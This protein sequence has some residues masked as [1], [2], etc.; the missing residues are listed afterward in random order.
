MAKKDELA[1]PQEHEILDSEFAVPFFDM[2]FPDNED[3]ELELLIDEARTNGTVS[4]V[5]NDSWV[6]E[7]PES[8]ADIDWLEWLEVSNSLLISLPHSIGCLSKLKVLK[9]ENNQIEELPDELGDLEQLIELDLY[10]NSITELP[11][12]VGN[13]NNLQELHLGYNQL[14]DLP[15]SL[16]ELE[17]LTTIDL[18]GNPLN[19]ALAAAYDEGLASLLRFL[20]ANAEGHIVLNEAKLILIGEGE[21][22]KSCLLGALR[23]DPWVEGNPTTHGIEIKTVDIVEPISK[24]AIRLNSWDF[25]GQRVYRPTHQLFFSAPAVYLVVWKPREGHQQGFV[26]EWIKLVKHREPDAKIIVV[27]TH[28]GPQ[29]RQPDIDRQEIVDIFGKDTICGFYHIDNKP[30]PSTGLRVGIPKL[31]NAIAILASKL[32]EMGHYF[33]LSWQKVRQELASKVTA[34]LSKK[35]FLDICETYSLDQEDAEVLLKICNRVGDLIYY[36]HDKLLRDFVILKPD[37]LATA[38]SLVLDDSETRNKRNGLISFERLSYLWSNPNKPTNMHYPAELHDVFL[39]LMERFDLSYRINEEGENIDRKTSLIAQLVPDIR[40][41]FAN[42]WGEEPDPGDQQQVQI[43]RVVSKESSNEHVHPTG[44][45]YQLIVRLH[46][47]SLGRDNY[48]KSIHWQKGLILEDDFGSRAFL[49]DKGND[50][51][52][53]VRSPY[54]QGFLSVITYEIKYLVKTY[55][56]G[57]VC[58][59]A[60]PCINENCNGLFQICN[61]IESKG[62]GRFDYPCPA[63]GNWYSI[64]Q[65]LHNAPEAQPNPMKKLLDRQS[66]VMS[67]MGKVGSFLKQLNT[68]HQATIGR[69]D[70][71][72]VDLKALVSQVGHS[73]EKLMRALQGKGKEG[74]RL[75]SLTPVNPRFLDKP[76]WVA[77]KFKVTLWCEHSRVP[78]PLINGPNSNAGVYEMELPKDWLVKSA[79]YCRTVSNV[80]R[81]VVPVSSSF[82]DQAINDTV[83]SSISSQ[84]EDGQKALDSLVNT[85]DNSDLNIESSSSST[86]KTPDN[87]PLSIDSSQ[88]RMFQKW[89]EEKDPGFGGL[90]RVLNNQQEY[91]WVHSKY[92]GDY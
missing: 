34:F 28:G 17:N 10:D 87:S 61:L 74:P 22:G 88:L 9:L 45:F 46:R 6:K 2:E 30:D 11:N 15:S 32:P 18:S 81:F 62:L 58:D 86:S 35:Q 80:L 84:L 51:H 66:E 72:A 82:I 26:H 92:V 53:V 20:Q 65:L 70:D 89:L 21:V 69:F 40:P 14:S 7:I 59:I 79:P 77:A 43:C 16:G 73:Y 31:K 49:Q 5:V 37:W 33:P 36:E 25:G 47:Y 75:F 60:V 52:I 64:D 39:R 83:F 24:S 55:W 71:I 85:V 90:V 4:L 38:I 1:K 13:L 44:L 3:D 19:P 91:I 42:V 67:E 57:V 23:D 54:P 27:A 8:I 68:N 63:C 41:D 56:K 48:S 50:I 76:K 78:L 12:T 29:A